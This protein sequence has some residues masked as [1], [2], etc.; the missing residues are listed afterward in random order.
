MRRFSFDRFWKSISEV[1][2]ED[3]D[4][5]AVSLLQSSALA[6]I[7]AMALVRMV[8]KTRESSRPDNDRDITNTIFQ[9]NKQNSGRT[10]S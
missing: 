9:S 5:S 2:D 7:V 4:F 3:G 10:I 1:T 6:G 8:E